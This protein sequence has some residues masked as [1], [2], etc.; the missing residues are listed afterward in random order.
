MGFLDIFKKKEEPEPEPTIYQVKTGDLPSWME[1]NLSDEMSEARRNIAKI[2]GDISDSFRQ[3][4]KSAENLG[5]STF[6]GTD[7]LQHRILLTGT[8]SKG[9]TTR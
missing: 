5:Q 9:C 6:H 1:Q 2:L 8:L 7:R 4:T 3:I